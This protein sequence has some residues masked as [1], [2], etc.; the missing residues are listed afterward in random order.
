M[1]RAN[2]NIE[3]STRQVRGSNS[4]ANAVNA[5]SNAI[6]E[7]RPHLVALRELVARQL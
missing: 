6:V 5:A 4:W 2:L 1:R 7:A 3:A